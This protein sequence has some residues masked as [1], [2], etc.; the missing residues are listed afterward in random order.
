MLGVAQ[1]TVTVIVAPLAAASLGFACRAHPLRP[2]DGFGAANEG[3]DERAGDMR[4]HGPD[5]LF[6]HVRGE[7]VRELEFDFA[8]IR[9]ERVKPPFAVQM[10]KWAAVE[11]HDDRLRRPVGV[12]GGE[13]GAHAVIVDVDARGLAALVRLEDRRA[14][15]PWQKHADSA[16][17]GRRDRTCPR[18]CRARAPTSSRSAWVDGYNT[19]CAGRRH[20]T[21]RA[22]GAAEPGPGR[23]Q[24]RDR[25]SK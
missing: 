16:P 2:V 17:P 9:R 20:A 13:M 8:G 6:Q 10:A 7:F 22:P 5:D 4:E 19:A 21:R 14:A 24:G 18:R 25:A 15:A 23:G 3:V 11:R 12:V 1:T